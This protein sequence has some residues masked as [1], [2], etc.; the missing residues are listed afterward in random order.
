[1]EDVSHFDG[2]WLHPSS[3]FDAQGAAELRGII[4]A[5]ESVASGERGSVP[6]LDEGIDA[7]QRIHNG[8]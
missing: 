7:V 1:V 5:L 2:L 6:G 4:L 8:S 3:Q